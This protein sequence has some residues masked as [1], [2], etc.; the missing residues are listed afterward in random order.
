MTKNEQPLF[1]RNCNRPF[2]RPKPTGR[3]PKH[4]SN[5]CRSAFYRGRT[6]LPTAP[7]SY[8]DDA[9][10]LTRALLTKAQAL[11]HRAQHPVP[12]LPL[13]CLETCVAMRRDLDDTIAVALR[14]AL[15]KGASW[16]QIAKVMTTTEG[17]LKGH[18][19]A[20]KVDKMLNDRARRGPTRQRQPAALQNTKSPP[21]VGQVNRLLPGQPGYPLSRALSYLRRTSGSSTVS[22]LAINSGVST[23]YIYRIM[24]G[25]RIPT[26]QVTADFARACDA[27]P[28]DLVFLWNT[29]HAVTALPPADNYPEAV[30]TLQAALRGLRLVS[31]NPDI[32]TLLR[33]AAA[34]LTARAAAALL[35]GEPPAA[36]YLRWPV[37][38]ALTNA[39]QGDPEAIRPLW[40]R[41]EAAGP[42]DDDG[43]RWP[44]AAF[45]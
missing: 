5:R 21:T 11:A 39:L 12:A 44:A 26:W 23:S 1:C 15:A 41:V 29:A 17:T 13:E 10:R 45:G 35:A 37:V 4:C 6:V 40:E 33:R 9:V 3:L 19:S 30:R 24:S 31:G 43:P 32:P 28:D 36:C 8:D 22:G 38:K 14:Q 20:E 42:P 2:K 25:E 27:D 18:Y 34:A 7:R 16:P